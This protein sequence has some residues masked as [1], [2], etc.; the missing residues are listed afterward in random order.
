MS[1]KGYRIGAGIVLMAALLCSCGNKGKG[2]SQSEGSLMKNFFEFLIKRNQYEELKTDELSGINDSE[3]KE[4]VMSWMWG[5]VDGNWENQYEIITSL[6]E[7]CQYVYACYTVMDEL[8]NGGFEQVF[9]NSSREFVLMAREGFENLGSEA[10][11]S[12][13]DKAITIYEE[14]KV[15]YESYRDGTVEGFS[16]LYKEK[17]FDGLDTEFLDGREKFYELAVAYI[18]EHESLFGNNIH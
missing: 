12:M 6:S 11:R 5:K 10:Y 3:L 8:E 16:N 13:M 2:D 1:K 15:L 9:Y 7:P 17:L 14:N 4:A 18:R